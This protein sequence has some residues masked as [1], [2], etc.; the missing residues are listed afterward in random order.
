MD[1]V[2]EILKEAPVVSIICT[3]VII[4]VL[5]YILRDQIIKYVKKNY[6]LLSKEEVQEMIDKSKKPLDFKITYD[7]E[8]HKN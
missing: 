7:D 3:T 4:L 8:S 1:K 5:I 6:N 2:F